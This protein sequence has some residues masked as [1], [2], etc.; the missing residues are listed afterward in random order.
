THGGLSGRARI[1]LEVVIAMIA[2]YAITRISQPNLAY[3]VAVPFLKDFFVPL[4]WGILLF[5]AF[6]IVGGGNAV[7]L[8]DGLDGLAI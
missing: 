8:T 4:G 5:G 3:S 2:V 1:V 7:N 6:V